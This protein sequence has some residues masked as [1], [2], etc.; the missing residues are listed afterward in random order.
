MIGIKPGSELKPAKNP[1]ITC[2]TIDDRNQVSFNGE[3]TSLS[4]AALQAFSQ[5]GFDDTALSGPW[6]WT[7]DGNR[8]Q[9]LFLTI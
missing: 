7:Y 5:L 8:A 1:D 3:V 9:S 6:E 4:D 2:K